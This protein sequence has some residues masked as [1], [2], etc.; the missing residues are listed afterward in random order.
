MAEGILLQL[1]HAA[2]QGVDLEGGARVTGRTHARKTNVLPHFFG[3]H[4]YNS[5]K[6]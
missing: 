4:L 3:E 5:L 1:V 6:V 2:A